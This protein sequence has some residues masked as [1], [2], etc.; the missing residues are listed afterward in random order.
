MRRFI[1][2]GP[3]MLYLLFLFLLT[4]S[5][6]SKLDSPVKAYQEAHNSGDVEKELSFFAEDVKYGVVGHWSIKGKE[7]LRKLVEIDAA[8]NSHIDVTGLKVEGD[9][10]T[11]KIKEQNDWLKLAKI[12]ALYYE[13]SEFIFEEGLIK[14]VRLKFT[15]KSFKA[16][17]EFQ[18]TFERWASKNRSQ[19]LAELKDPGMPIKESVGLRLRLLRE[20]REGGQEEKPTIEFPLFE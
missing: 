5:C 16:L 1:K 15:Q 12:G 20:W 13:Y 18:A 8:L 10:V 11:C 17:Q 19:E 9:I 7:K 14:E 3:I 6:T 4:T 2:K